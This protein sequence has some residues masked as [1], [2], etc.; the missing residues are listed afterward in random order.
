MRQKVVKKLTQKVIER[1]DLYLS[2]DKD[3]KGVWISTDRPTWKI[4]PDDDNPVA[5]FFSSNGESMRYMSANCFEAL[6]GIRN[7]DEVV[8]PEE[9]LH[10]QI[11]CIVMNR[12]DKYNQHINLRNT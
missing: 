10:L 12:Y 7:I 9:Y 5:G 6:F 3:G 8:M 11:P 4:V 2:R 1:N